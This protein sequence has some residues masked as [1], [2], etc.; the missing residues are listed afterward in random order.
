MTIITHAQ[1]KEYSEGWEKIFGK[2]LDLTQAL[3]ELGET[4]EEIHQILAERDCKGLRWAA[5]CCPVSNYLLQQGFQN[6]ATT[7]NTVIVGDWGDDN[8]PPSAFQEIRCSAHLSKFVIN[9]DNGK[10]PDLV[11]K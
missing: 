11:K 7:P 6:P 9:F 2:K 5:T 8:A 10:Y 4:E 3:Q 1:S